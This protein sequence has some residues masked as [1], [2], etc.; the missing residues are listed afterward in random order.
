MAPSGR[1]VLADQV[2]A[3]ADVFE[4]VDYWERTRDPSHF[5][6]RTIEQWREEVMRARLRWIEHRLVP[7]RLEF[8]WWGGSGR[9]QRLGD[10]G[11]SRTCSVGASAGARFPL[12]GV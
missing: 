9:L 12:A 3:S 11:F 10:I 1:F 7:Y 2:S 5:V 8:N 4:W 6:Q